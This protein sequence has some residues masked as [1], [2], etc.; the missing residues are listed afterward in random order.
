MTKG[1]FNIFE[2]VLY[3]LSA[4]NERYVS[5]AKVKF[6][7]NDLSFSSET[8][9][10]LLIHVFGSRILHAYRRAVADQRDVNRATVY[11]IA[12]RCVERRKGEKG[13]FKNA[14]HLLRWRPDE[15]VEAIYTSGFAVAGREPDVSRDYRCIA[16]RMSRRHK[17]SAVERIRRGLAKPRLTCLSFCRENSKMEFSDARGG[18]TEDFERYEK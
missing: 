11:E 10:M 7:R 5:E 6:A 13:K 4:C 1:E 9:S 18:N 15:S 8:F 2:P 3:I 17:S 12:I 16:L 14:F